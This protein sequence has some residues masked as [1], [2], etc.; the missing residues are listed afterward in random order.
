MQDNFEWMSVQQVASY[1]GVA[2]STVAKWRLREQ[3]PPYVRTAKSGIR[4]LRT[5][6]ISWLDDHKVTPEKRGQEHVS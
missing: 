1:L 2:S 4:Y 3:G 6:V 5:D